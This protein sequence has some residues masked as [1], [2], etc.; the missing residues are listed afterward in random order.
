M[1]YP[2]GT[3]LSSTLN[4]HGQP[5]LNVDSMLCAN[6]VPTTKYDQIIIPDHNQNYT[7]YVEEL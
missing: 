5:V 2:V 6:W 7:S 3:N 1:N 4:Q